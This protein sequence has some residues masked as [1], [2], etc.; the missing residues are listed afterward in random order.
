MTVKDFYSVHA[1]ATEP[2][3]PQS[4]TRCNCCIIV[5][6]QLSSIACVHS[7][8]FISVSIYCYGPSQAS[9][10]VRAALGSDAGVIA[11]TRAVGNAAR[12][13]GIT[14]IEQYYLSDK[15]EICGKPCVHLL[16][17]ACNSDEPA[18][19]V[20]LARRAAVAEKRL[21]VRNGANVWQ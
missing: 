1:A 18:K 12:K 11:S 14:T 17:D 19:G 8:R 20:I 21:V 9:R 6:V 10:R 3:K 2:S 4:Y 5:I 16:C 7:V 13:R 15:C